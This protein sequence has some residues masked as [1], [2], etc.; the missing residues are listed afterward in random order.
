MNNF[1]I[2]ETDSKILFN[3]SQKT[4]QLHKNNHSEIKPDE[5]KAVCKS[6]L[7]KAPEGTRLRVRA[8][9]ID[10]FNTIGF[11]TLK[12][13][14]KDL[15]VLDEEDYLK[16]KVKDTSKFKKFSQLELVVIKSIKK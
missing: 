4:F 2:T 5:I 1:K 6:F 8:L 7:E 12:S 9:G 16:G 15:E 14:D 10:K 3:Q 13:L 11:A